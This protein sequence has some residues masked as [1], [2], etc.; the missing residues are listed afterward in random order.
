MKIAH[1]I[2]L[3]GDLPGDYD[4]M[5][6]IDDEGNEYNPV[7]HELQVTDFRNYTTGEKF[8]A[9]VLYPGHTKDEIEPDWEDEEEE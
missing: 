1:L 2:A 4:V 8:T 5:L 3:L 6:A 9:I 7:Y